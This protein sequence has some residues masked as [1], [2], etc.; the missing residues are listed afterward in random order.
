MEPAKVKNKIGEIF[1]NMAYGPNFEDTKLAIEWLKTKQSSFF[2]YIKKPTEELNGTPL[3]LLSAIKQEHL[4]T[5]NVPDI[6]T[7]KTILE[8][9][10]K[11]WKVVNP[12][13]KTKI[14][15]KIGL[16]IE[17]KAELFA[18]LEILTRGILAKHTKSKATTLLAQYFQYYSA[19]AFCSD[20]EFKVKECGIAVGVISN[21]NYLPHLGLFI[22]PALA[23]GHNIVL[24]IGSQ[25]APAAFLL[26]EIALSVGLPEGTLR[27]IPSDDGELVPYFTM[28][29]V[30][31]ISLF[32]DLNNDKYRGFHNHNKHLIVL[33]T[34]KTP[35]LIFDSADL[36]AASEG[37]ID[38]SWSYQSMLPWSTDT[39]LVQENIF[40]MF[41]TKLKSK[42]TTLEV[43]TADNKSARI[44]INLNNTSQLNDLNNIMKQAKL[45]GIEVFRATDKSDVWNP[46]VLV[47]GQINH[48]ALG[49]K[50]GQSNVITVVAFRSID[51]AVGL[52]NNSKQGVWASV[53]SDNANLINE[54]TRKLK[55]SNI[56]V[57]GSY[58]LSPEVVI[59]PTKD[60][61]MGYFGGKEGFME[62]SSGPIVSKCTKLGRSDSVANVDSI[63]NTAKK[64]QESWQKIPSIQKQKIL[65]DF[66]ENLSPLK[67]SE[68]VND[69]LKSVYK[70]IHN[71][72]SSNPTSILCGYNL[73]SIREPRGLIV[74]DVCQCKNAELIITSIYEGNSL[75]VLSD[76]SSNSELKLLSSKMPN[77][78]LSVV[79][80]GTNI[81]EKLSK[82]EKISC[83]FGDDCQKI[84][85]SLPLR[86]SKK[87][88]NTPIQ[89]KDFYSKTGIIKNIL[90]NIGKS[91][92]CNF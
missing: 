11:S 60:S 54:L 87:Y 45:Q 31:I 42:L 52:A 69:L 91:S 19:F 4:C 76:D 13:E 63:V 81:L 39:I 36:D 7:V 37:V 49:S 26:Q 16:E 56:S 84:F 1:N 66:A 2:A 14:I 46:S 73:A 8:Q 86:D 55:I 5:I 68:W 72:S 30:K 3:L 83:Y 6:D 92:T 44:S 34:Y 23:A 24:Q 41:L 75:I 88:I 70:T 77:G 58:E 50:D 85:A 20:E 65:Q 32:V 57:N 29:S 89:M 18:Q 62:Y 33:S 40:P 28:D 67:S 21:D 59:S 43:S 90:S 61:G 74:I 22:A 38:S 10:E 12:L 17:R 82:N 71:P 80:H 9:E 78:V 79:P 53:W 27:I 35:A 64:A 15:N 51:E 48:N 47:G 25:L